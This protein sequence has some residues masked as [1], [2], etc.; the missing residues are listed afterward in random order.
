M[1]KYIGAHF[2]K[3]VSGSDL[4]FHNHDKTF[5]SF[6]GRSNVGKSSAI[7]TIL[8]K[9]LARS[10]NTPGAT[11]S[12]N[13]FQINDNL[14]FTDLPGYGYAK[15]SQKKR[16]QIRKMI[17]WFI[18]ESK[19][20][21][22]VNILVLDA[23]VGLTDY[24]QDILEI[25]N[26]LDEKIIILFNKIDKLNQKQLNHNFRKLL[27]ISLNIKIIKFSAVKSIGIEEF[28]NS[29]LENH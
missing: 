8:G 15:L 17:L 3:S 12:I 27:N 20:Q 22:R 11:Q 24:D 13:L 10:S 7:N 28:W 5:V 14:I 21:N 26:D 19:I 2:L 29:V 23:K 6:Y 18:V 9:K 25:L 4:I 1:R 16:E